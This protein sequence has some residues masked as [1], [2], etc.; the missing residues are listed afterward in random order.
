MY[1]LSNFSSPLVIY[2]KNLKAIIVY[3]II[4]LTAGIGFSPPPVVPPVMSSVVPP[5][6]CIRCIL[7]RLLYF[8]EIKQFKWIIAS[9][10]L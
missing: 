1:C 6:P 4:S 3:I 9:A 7:Y 5:V 10:F 8:W 2:F